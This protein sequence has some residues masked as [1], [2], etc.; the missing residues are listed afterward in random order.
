MPKNI[1]F[2]RHIIQKLS[3]KN[4]L[5]APHTQIIF[6]CGKAYTGEPGARQIFHEYAKRHLSEYIFLIAEDVFAN[7]EKNSLHDLLTLESYMA[8][9]SDC[10]I[11]MLET[12]STFAELGAFAYSDSIAKKI[13]IIN[14]KIHKDSKSF[15]NLGP[16]QKVNKKSKFGKTIYTDLCVVTSCV[17]EI[18]N[19]LSAIQRKVSISVKIE[20]IDELNSKHKERLLFLSELIWFF[21]P[22]TTKEIVYYLK[23][24][25][26]CGNFKHLQE[27]LAL[28]ESFKFIKKSNETSD[29]FYLFGEKRYDFIKFDISVR[30]QIRSRIITYY[31]KYHPLKMK[32]LSRESRYET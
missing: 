23:N 12:E 9:C 29:N 7:I 25:Y 27:D 2:D 18:K 4:F 13:L 6:L 11:I 1:L 28:L 19:R 26:A 8:D 20:N 22:I 5:L 14:D 21:S 32:I 16:I 31:A 3:P 24:H 10:I 30:S 15:V 17:A